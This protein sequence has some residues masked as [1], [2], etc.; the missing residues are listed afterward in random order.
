VRVEKPVS[1]V[2]QVV[3]DTNVLVAALRSR[4]GASHRLL[5]FVGDPRWRINL[6]VPLLLEYEDVLKRP[7]VGHS[8]SPEQVD[9]V[10][11]FLCASASLREIFYLWRPILTDPKDDFV[12]ELAV[13]SG[14]DYIVTGARVVKA[15]IF[16][17][18]STTQ[19]T[20]CSFSN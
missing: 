13:E 1:N 15:G 17:T 12:L 6:S 8:L 16:A 4:R 19:H 10:L 18:A 20:H 2:Y 11:D 3:L 9:D 7:D 14:C 5:K